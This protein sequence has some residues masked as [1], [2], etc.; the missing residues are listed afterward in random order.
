MPTNTR[1]LTA[2]IGSR[3]CHDLISPLGAIGNGVELLELS[4]LGDLPEMALIS[5]SVQNAN[6]RIRFFRVA[7]GAANSEQRVA[8][9]EIRTVLAPNADGRKI[10]IN[11]TPVGDQSR[12]AVKLAFLIIQCMETSM[13]WGGRLEIEEQNGQWRIWGEAEKLRVDPSLW[14]LLEADDD[15]ANVSPAQVHFALIGPELKRQGRTACV[16]LA[17]HSVSVSF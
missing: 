17:D 10:E 1:D 13:P 11:W 7:F 14:A 3:I 15:E 9:N 5:E 4:G 6:L 16:A 2:L 8:E 12:A